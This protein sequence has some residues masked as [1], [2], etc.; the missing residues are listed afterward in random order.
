MF[1]LSL[2][3]SSVAEIAQFYGMDALLAPEVQAAMVEI[4]EKVQETAQANTWSVFANP[5]GK[6]SG[7]IEP[8]VESPFEAQVG[9][10]VPQGRRL[11]EGFMDMTD[12]LG[13]TFHQ[14][15]RPYLRP[16]MTSQEQWALT[17]IE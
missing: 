7:S 8:I 6:L 4:S 16:A 13:R 5:T 14:R 15:P 11:E 17:K 9:V 3:P 1:S 10:G 12:S 2:A